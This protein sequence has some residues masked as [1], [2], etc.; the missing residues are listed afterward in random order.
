MTRTPVGPSQSSPKP[1]RPIVLS[2]AAIAVLAA[3]C[4]AAAWYFG[5]AGV[6][7]RYSHTDLVTLS[8]RT[9]DNPKDVAAW[10]EVGLRLAR[11][12]DPM[13]EQPLREA[14][15]LDP[16]D[17]EV[18]CALGELLTSRRQFGEAFQAL[19]ACVAHHPGFFL[20]RMALGRLYKIK[21]S[22]LHAIEQFQAAEKV[23]PS[24]PDAHYQLAICYLETEQS[25]RARTEIE[26]AL[27]LAPSEPRF[28]ALKGSVD[29]VTGNIDS[30]IAETQ[31]AAQL[32]PRDM[33]VQVTLAEILVGHQRGPGDLDHAAQ[34]I[35]VL[36]KLAP[37]YVL[38]PYLK[39]EVARL[40][41]D[42]VTAAHQLEQA[43]AAAPTQDEIYFSLSQSYRRAGRTSEAD[44]VLAVYRRRQ[45]IRRRIADAQVLISDH[46]NDVPLH[47]KL[48]DLQAQVG[49][50]DL[51]RS[52]LTDALQVDPNAQ[53]VKQRLAAL[54][55][56]KP[57][58]TRTP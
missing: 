35:A 7:L 31:R 21:V 19:S 8:R 32:A 3:I 4:G 15:S 10:R 20:G 42:Y 18:A 9:A 47:E 1:R 38:L 29:A 26:Q 5:P 24:S 12:G 33:K 39:G 34:Q 37:D 23:D 17:P 14:F 58:M 57:Q 46:P 54:R 53:S 41:G 11:D 30:A 51:A 36:E 13:A 22:Y 16:S 6:R 25:A 2:L 27:H 40:R 49:E 52:T 45:D 55:A 48:A 56:V 28:L 44:R 43:L 50:I